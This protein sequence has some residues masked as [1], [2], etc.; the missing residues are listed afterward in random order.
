MLASTGNTS[1]LGTVRSYLVIALGALLYCF[2]WTS[3]LIPHG[4]AGGGATGLASVVYYAT[5]G[6]I[7][8]SY[9]YFAL[10]FV[11]IVIGMIVLGKSFGFKTVYCILL[12][13]LFL[14][15]LPELITWRSDVEEPFLNAVI[16]GVIGGIGVAMIFMN[17]G[18]I[19][20]TDVVALIV[21]KY[22]EISPG[23]IFI[24]C[25]LV[26]VGSLL[27][28]PDKGFSDVVCGYLQ[29]ITFS[30]TLDL[31]LTGDKQSVQMLVFSQKYREIA[32]AVTRESGRG[33]TLV[34]G[35]GWY[36]Q[37]QSKILIVVMRKREF[38]EFTALVKHIDPD[39]FLTVTQVMGVYG[40]GFEQIKGR[41]N[42]SIWK[43]KLRKSLQ[44]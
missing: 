19:G 3:F 17:G 12:A 34:D 16:G 18:S 23:K 28:L 15:F 39:A 41:T 31:V 32:D 14:Q 4:I 35:T 37:S 40:N 6:L 33:V 25:D 20:G 26:I 27:F 7:P 2:S 22:R 30:Y 24:Y 44:K 11:L 8:V 43:Q 9:T 5:S 29:M 21:T 38:S 10:N 42:K 36:S 13:T 1:V